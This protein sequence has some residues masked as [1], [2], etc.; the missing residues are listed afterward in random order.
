[1]EI[2][3]HRN[4]VRL[5]GLLGIAASFAKTDRLPAVYSDR[6]IRYQVEIDGTD[7]GTFDSVVGLD[8]VHPV[9]TASNSF[10]TDSEARIVRRVTLHRDF[11]T[12]P[13]LYLWAQNVMNQ[14]SEPREVR[15][16]ATRPSGMI[17]ARYLLQTGQPLSWEIE[18]VNPAV[19][20]YHEH[21]D[22]AVGDIV[23]E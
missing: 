15:I 13:S 21:V 5:L 18:A 14:R 11:V 4:I 8:E 19:G 2:V 10:D 9:T 7:Y 22:L 16:L 12:E 6:G 17:V 20:G 3:G 23:V 1:M